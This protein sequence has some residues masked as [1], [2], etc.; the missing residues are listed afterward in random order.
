MKAYLLAAALIGLNASASTSAS[1]MTLGGSLARS[2]F[3]AADDRRASFQNLQICDRALTE[4]PL[5]TSDRVATFVNRGILR[6][7]SNNLLGANRDFDSALALN[8]NEP[9]A[10]LNKGITQI[11]EGKTEAALA[12]IDRAIQLR[13]RRPALAYYARGLVHEDLGGLRQ[14]YADLVRARELEP[15]WN[16]PA[17]ELR[18]YT[19]ARR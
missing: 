14:A 11:R 1:I 15:G 4:E 10:W 13:T 5:A 16:D 8:A 9:D 18:R 12:M 7:A 17:I 3:E 19:V 2:C 6:L